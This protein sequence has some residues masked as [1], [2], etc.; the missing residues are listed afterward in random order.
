LKADASVLLVDADL[1]S[2]RL[3]PLLG[4]PD[5]PGLSDVLAG[6]AALEEAV[7]RTEPLANL[8]V[9]PAGSASPNPAELFDSPAWPALAGRI[10]RE[11]QYA[12]VDC[13]PA[14]AVADYD[15]VQAQCDGLVVVVRPDATK[16]GPCLE[17]LAAAPR[18]KLIGIIVNCAPDW[19]LERRRR[20][21]YGYY[22]SYGAGA[23]ARR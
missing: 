5:S 22:G 13:P 16:I 20:G 10:R 3:A 12:V 9:L 11:F 18:D 1:R 7:V 6:S 8:C 19:F 2:R 15:L 14:G 23:A 21:Y 17:T 4:L